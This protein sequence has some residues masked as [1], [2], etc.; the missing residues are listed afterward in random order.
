MGQ[1]EDS[2]NSLK[3]YLEIASDGPN[4]EVAKQLVDSLQ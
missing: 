1:M 4:A 3:H 2:V